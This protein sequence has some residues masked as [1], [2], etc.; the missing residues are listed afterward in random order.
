MV[1]FSQSVTPT[2][3]EISSKIVELREAIAN[4]KKIYI[5]SGAGISVSAGIPVY[6]LNY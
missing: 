2:D 6:L 1:S 4:S 3:P 5:L